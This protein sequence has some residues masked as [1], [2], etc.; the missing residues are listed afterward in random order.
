M[1]DD[2]ETFRVPSAQGKQRKWGGGGGG[3]ESGEKNPRLASE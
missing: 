1:L 3:G 2:I